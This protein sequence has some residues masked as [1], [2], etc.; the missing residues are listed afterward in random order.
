MVLGKVTEEPPPPLPFI[1][2]I[3]LFWMDA[4]GARFE[5]VVQQ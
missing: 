1:I 3:N 2:L 5:G 4:G